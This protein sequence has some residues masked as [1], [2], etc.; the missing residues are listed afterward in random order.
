MAV[1]D[2]DIIIDALNG[3]PQ[4]REVLLK[5]KRGFISS[6][7]RAEIYFGMRKEE[8]YRTNALL[9]KFLEVPVDKQIVE[10]AY[11]IRDGERGL[12]LALYDTL[13]CATAVMKKDFIVTRNVR[14]F[15]AKLVK[16]FS[17]KY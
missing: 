1:F 12:T 15:P 5:Y 6:I 16:V 2:S 13:I 9:D 14:H 7:T 10:L 8:Y 3:V 17:P 11:N 4:A